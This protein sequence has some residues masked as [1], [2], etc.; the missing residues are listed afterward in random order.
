MWAELA[1]EID[2]PMVLPQ[3]Q[4]RPEGVIFQKFLAYIDVTEC[5][6]IVL[7]QRRPL[8]DADVCELGRAVVQQSAE[9]RLAGVQ[10]DGDGASVG[11]DAVTIQVMPAAASN[12][13]AAS[14][15]GAPGSQPI[16]QA[17]IAVKIAGPISPAMLRDELL[18]PCSRP[19]S[20]SPTRR[21]IRP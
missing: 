16:S 12:S 18:A 8:P 1:I 2:Q 7:H 14:R 15:K 21:V 6:A 3:V 17:N 13:A 5:R 20:D 19:C 10:A 11:D 4:Y 9:A